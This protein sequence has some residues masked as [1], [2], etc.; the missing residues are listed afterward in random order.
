[1][2]SASILA[3]I[4]L[5]VGLF[6]GWSSN[7]AL[8]NKRIAE[9]KKLRLEKKKNRQLKVL[10][11]FRIEVKNNVIR[12]KKELKRLALSK[13]LSEIELHFK[14]FNKRLHRIADKDLMIALRD[15]YIDINKLVS[16]NETLVSFI[17]K[18]IKPNE[19]IEEEAAALFYNS[20]A[21]TIIQRIKAAISTGQELVN[22]L[23]E[24]IEE[25]R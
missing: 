16:A 13:M 24:K 8:R 5:L 22:L 1:M 18:N 17:E 3:V 11:H 10:N 15:F 6:V 25:F 20:S 12:L 7:S 21:S 23:E 19:E 9:N 14:H 2:D 4:A